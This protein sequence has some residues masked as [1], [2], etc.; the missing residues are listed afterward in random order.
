M[1][2]TVVV[3]YT[4]DG[5]SYSEEVI[6]GN[7]KSAIQK[8]KAK[9][10]KE[11]VIIKQKCDDDGVPFDVKPIDTAIQQAKPSVV[12]ILGAS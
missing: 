8:V 6:A 3:K 11:G 2:P 12:E 10:R 5:V 1:P 7:A 9:L 4:I